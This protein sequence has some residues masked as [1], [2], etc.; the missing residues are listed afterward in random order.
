V[1]HRVVAGEDVE[2]PTVGVTVAVGDVAAVRVQEIVRRYVIASS[3][4]R[5]PTL[6]ELLNNYRLSKIAVLAEDTIEFEN[7]RR[8]ARH[9]GPCKRCWTADWCSRPWSAAENVSIRSR[10][11]ARSRR[12]SPGSHVGNGCGGPNGT[13][14]NLQ[15][16]SA[17]FHCALISSLRGPQRNAIRHRNPTRST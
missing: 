1:G 3:R 16:S 13:R 9:G 11:P 8:R 5:R 6:L 10:D 4:V 14:S 7:V 15:N 2:H 17:R 12:S